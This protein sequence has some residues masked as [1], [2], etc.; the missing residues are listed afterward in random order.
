[1]TNWKTSSDNNRKAI[2]RLYVINCQVKAQIIAAVRAQ[3][4]PRTLR[5]HAEE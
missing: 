1:M 4:K 3:K 5:E 2:L